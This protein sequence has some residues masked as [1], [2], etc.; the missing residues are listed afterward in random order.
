M[1]EQVLQRSS[2]SSEAEIALSNPALDQLEPQQPQVEP[3][4]NA[5]FDL[6]EKLLQSQPGTRD[7]EIFEKIREWTFSDFSRPAYQFAG[8]TKAELDAW[9]KRNR[10]NLSAG[11]IRPEH[12][13]L[14]RGYTWGH[15][16]IAAA[17]NRLHGTMGPPSADE[18]KLTWS[19]TSA[20]AD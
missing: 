15:F 1:S 7:A 12:I 4:A 2:P 13:D 18:V 10:I 11:H 8:V 19:K 14:Q 9:Q 5:L 17:A 6:Y 16:R 3:T 20:A